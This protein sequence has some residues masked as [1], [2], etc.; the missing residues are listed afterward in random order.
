MEVD[1][2]TAGDSAVHAAHAAPMTMDTA[3]RDIVN[4]ADKLDGIVNA[5]ATCMSKVLSIKN[6]EIGNGRLTLG[7]A[8][9]EE[10]EHFPTRDQLDEVKN[11]HSAYEFVLGA[12]RTANELRTC[13]TTTTNVLLTKFQNSETFCHSWVFTRELEVGEQSTLRVGGLRRAMYRDVVK[14]VN[15]WLLD[16]D[17]AMMIAFRDVTRD[18][19][20]EAPLQNLAHE[21]AE[22]IACRLTLLPDK[23]L[24]DQLSTESLQSRASEEVAGSMLQAEEAHRTDLLAL[25][26]FHTLAQHGPRSANGKVVVQQKLHHIQ[27][28]TCRPPVELGL[29]G[30]NAQRMNLPLLVRACERDLD[31]QVR[32]HIMQQWFESNGG[33]AAT[34]A[35]QA[36]QK[37]QL[38]GA[39]SS[40]DRPFIKVLHQPAEAPGAGAMEM[41]RM[42]F[43]HVVHRWTFAPLNAQR[44]MFNWMQRRC[45][46]MTSLVLQ[47]L[48]HG[49]LERGV[50]SAAV[51]APIATQA[52][53]EARV[54]MNLL[55][56]KRESLS[57]G[58]KLLKFCEDVSD[59][60][61]HLAPEV[62]EALLF[63]SRFSSLELLSIFSPQSPALRVIMP[64]FTFRT[65]VALGN[66]QTAPVVPSRYVAFAYDAMA[67]LLPVVRARRERAGVGPLQRSNP[68]RELLQT[69]PVVR[70]WSPLQGSLRLEL[71]DLKGRPPM[72]R[73]VLEQLVREKLLVEFKRP[74]LGKQKYAPRKAFVFN[75]AQLVAVLSGYPLVRASN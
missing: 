46:R 47:L 3:W 16:C 37:M 27:Y 50:L 31:S 7:Q 40:W 71:P 45:V 26:S 14:Q 73:H 23:A 6:A 62:S 57:L 44:C 51:V 33:F 22:S 58:T 8:L 20:D 66:Y 17:A 18:T 60:E 4:N 11:I 13:A 48:G 75:S 42:P 2:L 29:Q 61:S 65:R 49:A 72:L 28:V 55:D 34:A 67:I 5:M 25:R 59:L 74:Y 56:L 64:E 63:L 9:Y 21:L 10:I 35:A 32:D 70:S 39:R 43:V 52:I 38:W 15:R 36:I 68:V 12:H 30:A 54:V 24:G 69:V 1:A 41:P 19:A 53:L